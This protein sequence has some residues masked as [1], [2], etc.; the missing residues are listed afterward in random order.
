MSEQQYVK[1]KNEEIEFFLFP[2]STF[3]DIFIESLKD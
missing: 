2:H 3:S 1:K